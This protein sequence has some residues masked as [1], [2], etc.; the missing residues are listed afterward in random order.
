[1]QIDSTK[2]DRANM[3]ALKCDETASVA[4][5][6]FGKLPIELR[7]KIYDLTLPQRVVMVRL[8]DPN[9]PAS[10]T[11]AELQEVGAHLTRKS[12]LAD[13]N[14]VNCSGGRSSILTGIQ[15]SPYILEA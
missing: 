12:L 14:D 7:Y 4:A 11:D 10:A 9:K 2:A 15:L 8:R 1:M 13:S 5:H 3:A 6:P